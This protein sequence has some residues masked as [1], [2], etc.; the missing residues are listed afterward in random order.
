M[1]GGGF[2]QQAGIE[3]D[4]AN[5]GEA[6]RAGGQPAILVHRGIDDAAQAAGHLLWDGRGVGRADVQGGAAVDAVPDHRG[7]EHVFGMLME[8]GVDG[9]RRLAPIVCHEVHVGYGQ[10]PV[11]PHPDLAVGL[12]AAQH[13]DV[14]D[15]LGAGDS[16]ER[17]GG[18]PHGAEKIG[19]GEDFTPSLL[20][21]VVHGVPAGEHHDVAARS[22]Q[23][24]RF[25][26]EVVVDGQPF[27]V[28]RGIA[29]REVPERHV[30][31]DGGEAAVGHVGG[32]EALGTDLGRRIQVG[33][34]R[35]ADRVL[36][37]PDHLG[38]VGCQP[39]EG[40]RSAA[41][42][43]HTATA[44]SGVLHGFPHV[45]GDRRVGVVGVEGAG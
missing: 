24:Q 41:G 42:L 21:D 12:T 9:Q 35:G 38:V 25:D 39:D 27:R 26:D 2:G 6:G 15:H 45:L 37:H 44:E 17:G 34:H 33:G 28:V 30:A 10:P 22:G 18:Q 11:L 4:L 20:V 16:A 32:F 43:Q 19:A 8:V 1:A 13:E 40:A 5:V 14:G 3:V 31:D 36:L 7:A 29:Q 23:L